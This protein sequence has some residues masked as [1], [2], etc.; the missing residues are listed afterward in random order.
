MLVDRGADPRVTRADG[1]TALHMAAQNGRIDA[2]RYLIED[3]GL[4]VNVL[5]T[6]ARTASPL[7]LA[8]G[9][10]NLEV[11]KYLLGNGAKI[12]AGT[13]PLLFAAQV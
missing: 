5:T 8:A 11:C 2:V 12:D 3:C 7:F 13:Q 10:G 9:G 4:D 1:I 6:D